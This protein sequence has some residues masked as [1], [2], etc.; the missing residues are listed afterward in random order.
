MLDNS[1]CGVAFQTMSVIGKK[2]NQIQASGG[3]GDENSTTANSQP[4]KITPDHVLGLTT[5]TDD[6]LCS[7]GWN[8]FILWRLMFMIKVKKKNHF[9]EQKEINGIDRV[10]LIATV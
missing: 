10:N 6:Y 8:R 9:D 1:I 2:L 5:I 4:A 3:H 7:S